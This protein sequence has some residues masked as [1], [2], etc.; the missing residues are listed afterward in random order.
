MPQKSAELSPKLRGS[1]FDLGSLRDKDTRKGGLG[2]RAY[3][4]G[5]RRLKFVGEGLV[6][7]VFDFHLT[8]ML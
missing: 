8:L 5:L 4:P 1:A 2:R 6:V 3:A 7:K